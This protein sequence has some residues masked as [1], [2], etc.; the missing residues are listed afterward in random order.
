MKNTLLNAVRLFSV[1]LMAAFVSC[2]KDDD[3]TVVLSPAPVKGVGN[4]IRIVRN[5]ES[6]LNDA[7][8]KISDGNSFV[9]Y[10]YTMDLLD[11][12]TIYY[13]CSDTVNLNTGKYIDTQKSEKTGANG[14]Y[15]AKIVFTENGKE[16]TIYLF[17]YSE[18]ETFS[19]NIKIAIDGIPDKTIDVYKDLK[20]SLGKN[21]GNFTVNGITSELLA[22]DTSELKSKIAISAGTKDKT[23]GSVQ[24]N[25][26]SDFEVKTTTGKIHILFSYGN[27]KYQINLIKPE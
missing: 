3:E 9:K 13:G 14:R 7:V 11:N 8:F 17:S 19:D 20:Y 6:T 23:S 24:W 10:D 22:L 21:L 25:P 1:L 18:G 27:S 4:Y 12:F 26:V 2:S 5:S 15:A 16:Y